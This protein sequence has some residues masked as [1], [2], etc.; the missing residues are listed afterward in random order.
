MIKVLPQFKRK[1]AM[2]ISVI[3]HPLLTTSLLTLLIIY[4]KLLK[5]DISSFYIFVFMNIVPTLVWLFVKTKN[6]SYTNF[7]VSDQKQR[8]SLY[9]FMLSMLFTSVLVM[10]LMNE[11]NVFMIGL[12]IG[13]FMMFTA[14][15]TNHF[16]KVS[17]HVLINTY[18]AVCLLL[19]SNLGFLLLLLFTIVVAW[20]RVSLERHTKKEVTL[21]FI[22]GAVFGVL[23]LLQVYLTN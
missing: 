3:S 1:M 16:I 6:G 5:L 9:I 4:F 8:G 22:M 14:F 21:G 11:L 23:F 10:F 7:D 18:M 17:L 19:I 13:T 2:T 12:L 15:I 20:S